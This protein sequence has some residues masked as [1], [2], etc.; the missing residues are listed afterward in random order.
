MREGPK[1]TGFGLM[2]REKKFI[3]TLSYCDE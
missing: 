2:G 1:P 3:L